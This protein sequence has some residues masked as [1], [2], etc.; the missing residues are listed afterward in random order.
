[1]VH[2]GKLHED[3]SRWYFQQL[4]DAVDYCH[5]KGVHHRDLKHENL[6]LDSRG[7]LKVSDFGLSALSQQGVGLLHTTCGTPNYVAP[8]RRGM[9]VLIWGFPRGLRAC[10]GDQI[11]TAEFSCPPWFS[12]GAKLLIHKILDPNPKSHFHIE[13]IKNDPW[14]RRNYV[15]VGHGE[16]EEVNLE[17]VQA[18]FNNIEDHYATEQVET[19]DGGPLTVNAF[20]MITLS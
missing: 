19:K 4:I 17:D 13:G 1:M 20:D 7:N 15:P 12:S 3:E 18:V 8:E 6:L 10:K 2:Q 5:S 11:N 9:V 14:S 16:Q